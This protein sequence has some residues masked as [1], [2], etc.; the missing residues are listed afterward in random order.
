MTNYG[1]QM[2]QY[3]KKNNLTRKGFARTL[4]MR[5][6]NLYRW[7][8]YNKGISPLWLSELKRRGVIKEGC[9]KEG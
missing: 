9:A 2:K 3:R 6:M 7:E 1:Q 5:P 4:G 8:E